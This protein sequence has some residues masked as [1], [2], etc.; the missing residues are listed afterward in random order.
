MLSCICVQDIKTNWNLLFI[1][2]TEAAEEAGEGLAVEKLDCVVHRFRCMRR[3]FYNITWSEQLVG[4]KS[5]ASYSYRREKLCDAIVRRCSGE[6]LRGLQSRP[7]SKRYSRIENACLNLVDCFSGDHSHCKE[8][9]FICPSLKNLNYLPYS[10]PIYPTNT[11]R[12]NLDVL[13]RKFI[14]RPSLIRLRFGL[15]TN[16]V[17]A[18]HH[19][20]LHVLPKTKT[21]KRNYLGRNSS[22]MHSHTFGCGA[23]LVLFN[24]KAGT[25]IRSTGALSFLQRLD[26]RARAHRQYRRRAAVRAR[27]AARKFHRLNLKK[28]SQ[29]NIR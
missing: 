18:L 14:N 22:A 23:S 19:H 11:D 13:I 27:R 6:V 12:V 1:W 25:K 3:A 5:Y 29:L 17:E 24:K 20:S 2:F 9:S 26:G 7:P 28:F 15:S 16:D 8:L 10:Q 4:K 21:M